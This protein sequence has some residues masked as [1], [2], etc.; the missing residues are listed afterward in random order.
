MLGLARLRS[1][2]EPSGK[3]AGPLQARR[4]L[5]HPAPPPPPFGIPPAGSGFPPV[6]PSAH[7]PRDHLTRQG[8]VPAA[9]R[10][11]RSICRP[12]P[13]QPARWRWPR[14]RCAL[15]ACLCGIPRRGRR[16]RARAAPARCAQW[17][18]THASPTCLLGWRSARPPHAASPA[19]RATARPPPPLSPP[20]PAGSPRPIGR[21]ATAA[22]G[23]TLGRGRCSQNASVF[24][25]PPLTPVPPVPPRPQENQVE[26]SCRQHPKAY[27]SHQPSSSL[28]SELHVMLR[29]QQPMIFL[30]RC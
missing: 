22:C 21:R 12:P 29:H 20:A 15:L 27:P 11:E 13:P 9:A 17:G 30:N 16:R 24:S 26:E 28:L 1:V 23:R 4:P 14:G 18:S 5:L 19:P 10:F 6:Y 7:R 8:A 25:S 2:R 3:L